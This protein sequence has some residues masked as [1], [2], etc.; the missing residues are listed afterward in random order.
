VFEQDDFGLVPKIRCLGE[1]SS[2]ESLL[3]AECVIID[4]VKSIS[5]NEALFSFF[6][7]IRMQGGQQRE[8][9]KKKIKLESLGANEKL[10]RSYQ[11]KKIRSPRKR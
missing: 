3:G 7:S 1:F 4:L 10:C 11:V 2:V 9:R 5:I 6:I 8:K